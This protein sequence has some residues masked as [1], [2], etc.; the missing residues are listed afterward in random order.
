MHELLAHDLQQ[1]RCSDLEITSK[2]Q[3]TRMAQGFLA[4]P[5]TFAAKN[6][7]G[8]NRANPVLGRRT[9]LGKMLGHRRA[10][11]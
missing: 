9:V 10:A 4:F 2:P 1:A 8:L 5:R 11:P 3:E 6:K 7:T